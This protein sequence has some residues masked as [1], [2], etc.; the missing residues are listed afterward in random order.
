MKF[1][2]HL[3]TFQENWNDDLYVLIKK[4]KEMGFDGVEIPLMNP[5][6]FDTLKTKK[7]LTDLNLECTCG[8][9]LNKNEDISSLDNDI[10]DRG[11]TRLHKCIDISSELNADVLG[12]VLY[13][14]WGLCVS[15]NEF[16][17]N[18]QVMIKSLQE[19]DK[20]AKSK[21][22]ILALELINRYESSVLNTVEDGLELLKQL[23]CT[24]IKLHFDTFHANIEEKN[25][26]QAIISGGEAIYHVHV[27]ENDRG[28]LGTGSIN[29][30]EVKE[31][32]DII[33]YD[34]WITIENFVVSNCEVGNDTFTYRNIEKNGFQSAIIGLKYL[35][36]L[37]NREG[38]KMKLNNKDNKQILIN[39]AD[40]FIEKKMELASYD[41]VIGDGDHGITMARGAKVAKA[42][43]IL[44]ED[45]TIRDYYKSYGRTLVSTLG[46]AMGPLFGSI[47][48]EVSKITK[49]KEE[50]GVKEFAEGFENAMLKVMEL[51]GA[52]PNDKTMVDSMDTVVTSL[53]DSATKGL[54]LKEAFEL[55]TQAGI[56]GVEK[57]KPLIAKRGRSKFLQEKA[58]G[59]QDA[60]ATSFAYMIS[61]INDYIGGK[62]ND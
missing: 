42:N 15:R 44:I 50:I 23:N 12:G 1:G 10:R 22:V 56:D 47:F 55:A 60:G 9:G 31:A 6:S 18:Y 49:N 14:P 32:L 59:Y 58:I 7:L 26:K 27:C 8:T 25:T 57:T 35:K 51:G 38:N 48:L 30:K 17:D 4:S 19:V 46:G 36:K 43:L 24:N 13:A 61:V 11:I 5:D 53:K 21:N 28:A 20:Y 16:K 29:F 41:A 33:G 45:G 54:D 52:K 2:V 62:F 34:N 37:F 40:M 39:I 3:S